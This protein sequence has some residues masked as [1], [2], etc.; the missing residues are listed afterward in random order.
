MVLLTAQVKYLDDFVGCSVD[1]PLLPVAK[2]SNYYH[3]KIAE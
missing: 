2:P 3:A 1:I